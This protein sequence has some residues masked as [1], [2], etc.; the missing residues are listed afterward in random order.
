MKNYNQDS[1]KKEKND[2]IFQKRSKG[3]LKRFIFCARLL[4]RHS[5]REGAADA[6][7]NK[8]IRLSE[9]RGRITATRRRV[10]RWVVRSRE[11]AGTQLIPQRPNITMRQAQPAAPRQWKKWQ[12]Q[13]QSTPKW[14]YP[15]TSTA[16]PC[17]TQAPPTRWPTATPLPTTQDTTGLTTGATLPTPPMPPWPKTGPTT[18]TDH[19]HHPHTAATIQTATGRRVGRL[20]WPL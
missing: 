3:K 12:S 20:G 10:G 9:K 15:K 8:K 14:K 7:V 1:K 18:T 13:K 19:P 16:R 17:L 2:D 5:E 6:K 11:S 4:L